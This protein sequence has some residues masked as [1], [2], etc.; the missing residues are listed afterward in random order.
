MFDQAAYIILEALTVLTFV[1]VVFGIPLGD[2]L[3]RKE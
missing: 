1:V 2:K 3:F